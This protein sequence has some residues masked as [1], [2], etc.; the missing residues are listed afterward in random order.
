MIKVYFEQ[1]G[2]NRASWSTTVSRL[3]EK[4]IIRE[5]R[6]RGRLMSSQVELNFAPERGTGSIIAGDHV[7]GS[8]R[9]ELPP[10]P[11]APERIAT[12]AAQVFKGEQLD[13]F[14][15]L[16]LRG[17]L[18]GL[19]VLAHIGDDWPMVTVLLAAIRALPAQEPAP[20]AG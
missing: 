10:T 12:L 15:R 16:P 6:N 7:V 1:V 19:A 13:S 18:V 4:S 9:V 5:A 3:S 14:L 20:V 11:I 8:F 2:R 17:Q